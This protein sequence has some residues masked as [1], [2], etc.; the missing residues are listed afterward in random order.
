MVV[1]KIVEIDEERCDGCG[2]CA[3]ACHE[4][5]IQIVNGK[6][7]LVSDT[8]C[9]GLGDCLQECPRD[10][11]TVIEREADEYDAEAVEERIADARQ[12]PG[13][14]RAPGAATQLRQWPVQLMLVP[15]TAPFLKG[16]DILVTADCVPFAAANYHDKYLAGRVTVVGCPKFDDIQH[17]YE[18]LKLMFAEARPASIAVVRME[19]P[20]CG[21]IAQ[22]VTRARADV[23]P[24]TELTIITIGIHGDEKSVERVPSP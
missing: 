12:A 4:G 11:I 15:P 6:A 10:A 19:V 24:D 8:Y 2:L 14:K 21:G 5:A 13:A 3:T 22:V 23:V 18:K 20:C 9:D 7:K 1:R 16:A 17:Y